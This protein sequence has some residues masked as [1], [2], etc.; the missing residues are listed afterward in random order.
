MANIKNT[1]TTEPAAPRPAEAKVGMELLCEAFETG[2]PVT[3]KVIGADARWIRLKLD[4][5][6]REWLVKP[7]RV[8]LAKASWQ[9]VA[10]DYP[11]IA[12]D[13]EFDKEFRPPVVEKQDP[14]KAK[15]IAEAAAKLK[16]LLPENLRSFTDD[17]VQGATDRVLGG[18]N[19]TKLAR[20]KGRGTLD[21]PYLDRTTRTTKRGAVEG[22]EGW[23]A[24]QTIQKFAAHFET[25]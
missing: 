6:E 2:G 21:A 14:E 15:Q 12:A 17:I 4:D 25:L 9:H 8:D 3:G 1:I 11:A 16:A 19:G 24:I 23:F 20:W 22:A 10:A 5:P 7:E 18:P 13:P